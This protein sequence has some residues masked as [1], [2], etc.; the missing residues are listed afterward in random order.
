MINDTFA[1]NINGRLSNGMF[2]F[3]DYSIRSRTVIMIVVAKLYY[4]DERSNL[5]AQLRNASLQYVYDK[6]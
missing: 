4:T 1:Y 2:K 3:S 5:Q 6:L